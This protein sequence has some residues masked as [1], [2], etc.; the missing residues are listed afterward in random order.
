M[1]TRMLYALALLLLLAACAPRPT[2]EVRPVPGVKVKVPVEVPKPGGV[3]Q[4]AQMSVIKVLPG[5]PLPPAGAA[6]ADDFSQYPVGPVL[7]AVAPD[8]Y[9]LVRFKPDWQQVT[10]IEALDPGGRLNPAVRLEGRDGLLTTGA[11]DWTDYRVRFRLKVEATPFTNPRVRVWLFMNGA[12]SRALEVE[13]GPNGVQLAK[14]AGEQRFVLVDRRELSGLGQ[15]LI[16]DKRWHDFRFD[17][18]KTGR[19]QVFFD[20]TQLIDWTDPDYR[21]GGFGVGPAGTLFY[22]DDL[23]IERITP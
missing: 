19:V 16:R 1:R 4:G 14:L 8:R 2:V 6:F 21:R 12:G 7:P 5:N 17:L 22:L 3:S 13:I 23:R 20:K 10:I 11:E 15:T 18:Q 9:G